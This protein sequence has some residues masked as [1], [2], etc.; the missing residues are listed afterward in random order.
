MIRSTEYRMGELHVHQQRD[1]AHGMRCHCLF[2]HKNERMKKILSELKMSGNPTM[3]MYEYLPN[4][5]SERCLIN[6]TADHKKSPHRECMASCRF[7]LCYLNHSQKDC[8]R[9]MQHSDKNIVDV[10]SI[11]SF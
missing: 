4:T 10:R 9:S 8:I 6:L 7:C 5:T 3:T 2:Q 11:N 1:Q